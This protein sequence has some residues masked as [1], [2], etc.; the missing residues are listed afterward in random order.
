[1]IKIPVKTIEPKAEPV[2]AV[3]PN[4]ISIDQMFERAKD[5]IFPKMPFSEYAKLPAVNASLLKNATPLEM[6]WYL[7]NRD[8]QT[9]AMMK[10]NVV[11]HAVLEPHVFATDEWQKYYQVFTA[12]KTLN[13]KAA[14]EAM[15]ADP[16]TLITPEMLEQA[17]YSR[18]AVWRH[19]EAARLLEAY[20]QS[21]VTAQVW[22]EDFQCMR[23][24]RI[25]RLPDDPSLPLFDLKTTSNGITEAEFRRSIYNYEYD[26]QLAFYQDTLAMLEK[27]V[28]P[29]MIVAVTSTA[30]YMARVF[31]IADELA[32]YSFLARGRKT[33]L[34]R[35][36]ALSLA[37]HENKKFGAYEDEGA[38]IMLTSSVKK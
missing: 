38:H 31:Y 24:I 21:E 1:M 35:M 26:L 23:K 14:Q 36:A 30:P 27:K 4:T 2:V 18:D 5:G 32:D 19:K 9:G 15:A 28:R 25:D 13:S 34:E 29:T 10:G 6:Q 22:D 8:N 20:G 11:H 7:E 33:Y 37:Y 17:R 3:K 16:R 12:T